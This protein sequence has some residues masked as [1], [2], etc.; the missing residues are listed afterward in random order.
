MSRLGASASLI[1]CVL[2]A[3]G[4]LA[5]SIEHGT[6]SSLTG[7]ANRFITAPDA[8]DPPSKSGKEVVRVAVGDGHFVFVQMAGGAVGIVAE[9]VQ[10][11]QILRTMTATFRTTPLRIFESVAGTR[12]KAP[13]ALTR[14]HQQR[15]AARGPVGALP[16]AGSVSVSAASAFGD[17]SL[18]Q[19]AGAACID[20]HDEP[21][22]YFTDWWNGLFY[23]PGI[24]T[25]ANIGAHGQVGIGIWDD[26]PANLTLGSTSAGAA[27]VCFPEGESSTNGARI[28]V[29]EYWGNGL[30]LDLWANPNVYQGAAY[31]YWFEGYLV[32]K[33][34]VLIRDTRPVN[35]QNPMI[36]PFYWAGTY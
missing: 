32:H 25:L 8:P 31:G 18:G 6:P 10:A 29:Q 11:A 23:I 33:V 3:A 34:R 17:S 35:Q 20:G 2:L 14:D 27:L 12:R 9:G 13:A 21:F 30:W 19:I 26:G 7:A 4:P 1:A 5:V 36:G 28:T 15:E 16:T 24:G 22:D